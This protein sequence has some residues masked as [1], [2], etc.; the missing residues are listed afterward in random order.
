MFEY[1]RIC[2][3]M[4]GHLLS[5]PS[6]LPAHVAALATSNWLHNIVRRWYTCL[7][8]SNMCAGFVMKVIPLVAMTNELFPVVLVS[9]LLA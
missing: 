2:F 4:L 8:E 9:T 7:I 6:S 1:E 5:Q 3:V